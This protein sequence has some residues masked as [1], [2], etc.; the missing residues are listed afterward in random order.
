M[1][2]WKGKEDRGMEAERDDKL[3]PDLQ[4]RPS[5]SPAPLIR[6]AMLKRGSQKGRVFS[7]MHLKN[8]VP[9]PD[10]LSVR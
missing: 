6:Q 4:E 10:F 8:T 5:R 2:V 1:R 7:V 9:L 3:L